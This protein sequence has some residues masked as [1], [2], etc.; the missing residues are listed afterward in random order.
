[1]ARGAASTKSMG[2]LLAALSD[3]GKK[4]PGIH[5]F[6]LAFYMAWYHMTFFGESWIR[7]NAAGPV[8]RIFLFVAPSLTLVAAFVAAAFLPRRTLRVLSLPLAISGFALVATAGSLL[9]LFSVGFLTPFFFGLGSCVSAAGMAPLAVRIGLDLAEEGPKRAFLF[10]SASSVLSMLIWFVVS[11]VTLISAGLVLALLPMTTTA[12]VLTGPYRKGGKRADEAEE[13]ERGLRVSLVDFWRFFSAFFVF[14]AVAGMGR[15]LFLDASQ[16][17]YL[18]SMMFLALVSCLSLMLLAVKGLSVSMLRGVYYLVVVSC[19]FALL[20]VFAVGVDAHWMF[21][22]TNALYL[23]LDVL[24]WCLIAA[25]AFVGRKRALCIVAF[26]RA[27]FLAGSI[28]GYLLG[29]GYLKSIYSFQGG[30]YLW[31]ALVLVVVCCATVVL[32]GGNLVELTQVSIQEAPEVTDRSAFDL[33]QARE[34]YL[35]HKCERIAAQYHLPPR[36]AEVLGMLAAGRGNKEIAEELCM[37]LNTVRT[38][39]QNIYQK[40]DVHSRSD[41]ASFIEQY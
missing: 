12:L 34:E 11:C 5:C 19:V 28:A 36:T 18:H 31:V 22:L 3:E 9:M 27:A 33:Q 4:W 10:I 15:V 14:A 23:V 25:A 40:L 41:L 2:G 7:F 38:H 20:L 6:A 37:G 1:M 39:V 26:G 32:S 16:E 21:E 24:S 35:N 17:G 13:G 8:E 30:E 29:A